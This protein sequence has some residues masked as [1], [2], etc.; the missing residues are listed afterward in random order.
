MN[1]VHY[2]HF[3]E[4]YSVDKMSGTSETINVKGG[5]TV[6]FVLETDTVK[7]A[8]AKC[9]MRDNFNRRIGR[10]IA[11]NRLQL[12][13]NNQKVDKI[14]SEVGEFTIEKLSSCTPKQ[15]DQ[16]VHEHIEQEILCKT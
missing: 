8:I 3:R 7:F 6:A 1:T 4:T 14:K 16:L 9:H 13:L 11:T 2:L 12:F 10:T 15:I 5:A